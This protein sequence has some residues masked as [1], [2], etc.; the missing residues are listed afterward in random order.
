MVMQ[1]CEIK[2]DW[3]WRVLGGKRLADICGDCWCEI[4]IGFNVKWHKSLSI[5]RWKRVFVG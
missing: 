4:Q 5:K 1:I 2:C 3:M